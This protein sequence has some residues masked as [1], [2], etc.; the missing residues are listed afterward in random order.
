MMKI[1]FDLI[2][3]KPAS[4]V[5]TAAH[6]GDAKVALRFNPEHWLTSTTPKMCSIEVTEEDI[7][8]LIRGV[9]IRHPLKKVVDQ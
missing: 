2:E 6:G 1:V 3:M 4:P 8:L 9:N 7:Q 5:L